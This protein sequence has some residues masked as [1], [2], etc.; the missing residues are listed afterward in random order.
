MEC[1]DFWKMEQEINQ[2]AISELKTAV[3]AHGG[4]YVFYQIDVEDMSD[5]E[6]EENDDKRENAP[7]VSLDHFCYGLISLIVSRM[8]THDGVLICGEDENRLGYSI[9]V[10]ALELSAS[11]I[12]HIIE[13]MEEPGKHISAQM[14]E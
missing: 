1:T 13:C 2:Q 3:N 8:S 5:E 6:M 14:S 4:E 7:I 11:N 10:S 9:N 12:Q